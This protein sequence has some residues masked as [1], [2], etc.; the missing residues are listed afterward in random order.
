MLFLKD[1]FSSSAPTLPLETQHTSL[2]RRKDQHI[3]A[4]AALYSP[5]MERN[6]VLIVFIHF[7]TY[8]YFFKLF[9][10]IV[11]IKYCLKLI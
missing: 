1:P 9:V 4:P 11:C 2:R 7:G 3:Q 6:E 10:V 8:L 5:I